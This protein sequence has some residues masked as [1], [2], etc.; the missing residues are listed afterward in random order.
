MNSLE[1][2]TW[3]RAALVQTKCVHSSLYMEPG[4]RDAWWKVGDAVDALEEAIARLEPRVEEV[5]P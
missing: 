5:Q 3:L 4:Q 1:A 2:V